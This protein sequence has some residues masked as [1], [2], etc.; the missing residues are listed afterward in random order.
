MKHNK[1]TIC[2]SRMSLSGISTLFNTRRDPQLQIL[3]RTPSFGFTLIELL[4]VVLIIGILSAIALPQYEKAVEKSRAA[5]AITILTYMHKQAEIC[6]M[7][8]GGNCNGKTN[9]ELGID[10]GNAYQCQD[11]DYGTLCCNKYW[12]Y[13]NNGADWGD[14]CP[15]SSNTTPIAARVDGIPADFGEVDRRYLLEFE[16]CEGASGKIACYESDKWCN[17][18]R[19]KGNPIQ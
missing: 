15:I 11:Y 13:N 8:S 4:V 10:L 16:D 12:C 2:H 7:E 1:L 19:G 6:K 3:E 14:D 5:E 17:M 9:E 18:F